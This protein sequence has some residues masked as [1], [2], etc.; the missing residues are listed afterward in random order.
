MNVTRWLLH[1]TMLPLHRLFATVTQLVID[2][3][4]QSECRCSFWRPHAE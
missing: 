2:R 1:D 3:V 4:V